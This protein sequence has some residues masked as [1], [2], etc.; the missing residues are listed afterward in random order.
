MSDVS[1][2]GIK[3]KLGNLTLKKPGKK[4]CSLLVKKI[5]KWLSSLRKPLRLLIPKE[6]AVMKQKFE[7]ALT[8]GVDFGWLISPW[9][10]RKK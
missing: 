5:D 7:S 8:A 2:F 10:R 9:L 6:V 1:L 3:V 4:L